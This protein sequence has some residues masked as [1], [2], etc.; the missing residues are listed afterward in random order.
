MAELRLWFWAG[1]A[2]GAV[3]LALVGAAVGDVCGGRPGAWV[4]AA[5]ALGLIAWGDRGRN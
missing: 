5:F 4:G 1:Y 2:A 3:V